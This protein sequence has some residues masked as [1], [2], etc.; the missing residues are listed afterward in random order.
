[1][2][3]LKSKQRRD[4]QHIC[5]VYIP[6]LAFLVRLCDTSTSTRQYS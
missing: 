1:M 2:T 3:V 6:T 5:I 4:N